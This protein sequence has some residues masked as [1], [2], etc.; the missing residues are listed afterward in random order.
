MPY[1][2]W[3]GVNIFG[4]F[5]HGKVFA[6]SEED[7]DSI[8]FSRNISLISCSRA[9]MWLMFS[10]VSGDDKINFFRQL[11]AL[12]GAGV[13]L[14]DALSILGDQVDNIRLSQI[15]FNL[16]SDIQEGVSFSSSLS[17]HPEVF[18]DLMIKMVRVGQASGNLSGSLGQLGDYLA[19]KYS[20]YKKL[21]SA[22]MLPLITLLFFLFVTL[23]IFIFIV[24]K[25]ADLFKSLNKELPPLT[26]V[27]LGVSSFFRSNSFIF[28]VS[29]LALLILFLRKYFRNVTDNNLVE[30]LFLKL[31]VVGT[32]IK[33]SFLVYF[34]RSISMLLESGV[35]LIPAIIISK[36][37]LGN[38]LLRQ[39]IEGLEQE[40]SDG[41]SLSQS[42]EDYHALLFSQ[43]V[44]SLVR[45][46]EEI[47]RLDVM[48]KKAANMYQDKV[49]R[50]I[51]FFTTIFQPLLMILLGLLITLLIFAVYVPVF[52]L[53]DIT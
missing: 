9:R 20:F 48:L 44:V 36:K 50:S 5:R 3:R 39:H 38:S 13:C 17:K 32:I 40:I 16:E 51:L 4:D 47:G 29:F 14:P 35:R 31:P 41:N 6:R 18:D 27:I 49:D 21:R 46:G 1:F 25:F 2:K 23:S 30:K 22:A 43:D 53:A 26:S 42:M 52:N 37:T 19:I 33:Q 10:R 8:L 28:L 15:I 24:P 12:I 34:L 7:L 45:V 11:S